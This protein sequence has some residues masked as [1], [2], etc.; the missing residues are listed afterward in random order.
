MMAKQIL[1]DGAFKN[2]CS[3]IPIVTVV[4]TVFLKSLSNQKYQ[5]DQIFKST[6]F[7]VALNPEGSCN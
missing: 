4:N 6:E 3:K 1:S 5:Q 7:L 2:I